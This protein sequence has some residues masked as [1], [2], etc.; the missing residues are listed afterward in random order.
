MDWAHNKCYVRFTTGLASNQVLMK[1]IERQKKC[2]ENDFK[3]TNKEVKR[4]FKL[5]YK[6]K[7]WKFE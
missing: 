6:A 7:S 2:V 4:Y 5:D 1:M 3:K